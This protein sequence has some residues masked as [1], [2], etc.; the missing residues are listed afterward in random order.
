MRI[1]ENICYVF[2]QLAERSLQIRVFSEVTAI[3]EE[4]GA[5]F[6]AKHCFTAS[7][8][9]FSVSFRGALSVRWTTIY[10]SYLQ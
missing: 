8:S 5:K 6:I 7:Y 4:G 1:L 3:T 2:I 9:I 10:Q